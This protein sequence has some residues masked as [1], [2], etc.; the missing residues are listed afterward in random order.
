MK[1]C[2]SFFLLLILTTGYSQNNI[3]I[4]SAEGE[5]FTLTVFD[6]IQNKTPQANV[7]VQSIFEDT[8]KIKIE[9]ENKSKL[10]TVIFLYEK[11]KPTKNK[12]FNYKVSQVQNKL[13]IS[14]AAYFDIKQLPN[15]L[16]PIKPIVDTSTKYKNTRLGHFCE[17]KDYQIIYF[18]NIPKDE[19][20]KQGMPIEYLN[21]TNIIM[22]KAQVED[23]KFIIAENICRNNCLTTEQLSFIL[24][25][26]AFEIEKLKIIRIAYF[27]LT[28]NKNKK[29]LEKSFRFESSINELNKFFEIATDPKTLSKVN[30]KIASSDADIKSL[31]ENLTVC[32]SDAQ[33]IEVFKKTYNNNCYSKTQILDILAVFIHDREKLD[34]AKMLYYRCV[35]KDQFLMILEVF[36]YNETKS[37]LKDFVAKQKD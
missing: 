5:L 17:L 18:N 20:C 25:F 33:R 14:Y 8:L 30:C 12:E 2:V 32:T 15:P 26:I 24:K 3:R 21:Y 27:N 16:V 1:L 29:D 35:E 19:V 13:I 37:E 31:I 36:S 23:D 28:D 22:A 34:V 9:F 7:L 4:F 11:G 6:T 10:E